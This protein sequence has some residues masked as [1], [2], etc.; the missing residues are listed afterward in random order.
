MLAGVQ[1]VSTAVQVVGTG[2]VLG[3]A[4]WKRGQL[5]RC[6]VRFWSACASFNH[7][8][9]ITHLPENARLVVYPLPD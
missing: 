9:V 5:R 3:S 2:I 4:V 1:V 8:H 7:N 6:R